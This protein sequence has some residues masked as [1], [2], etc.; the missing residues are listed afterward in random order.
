ME[1]MEKRHK[2][3]LLSE[4][5]K[6]LHAFMMHFERAF[7]WADSERGRFREDFFPPVVMAVL[8]EPVAAGR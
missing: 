6:L 4:E 1:D 8:P 7:A 3:F 5:L 2:N